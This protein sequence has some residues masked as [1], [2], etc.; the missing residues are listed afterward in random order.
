[1]D[2][3]RKTLLGLFSIAYRS[4]CS[5]PI[6]ISTVCMALG[7][8]FRLDFQLEA[9][10]QEDEEEVEESEELEEEF[11][12][13]ESDNSDQDQEQIEELNRR[14]EERVRRTENGCMGLRV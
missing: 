14:T 6:I 7:F 3:L 10:P 4:R 1:M 11:Y 13:E 8:T 5:I 12:E 9:E 2:K